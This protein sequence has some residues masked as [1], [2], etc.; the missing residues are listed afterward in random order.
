[1][2]KILIVVGLHVFCMTTSVLSD[3]SENAKNVVSSNMIVDH[4]YTVPEG[5]DGQKTSVNYGEIKHFRYYSKTAESDRNATIILPPNYTKSK[6]YPVLYLLHGL[7]A[8]EYQWLGGKPNEIIFNLVDEGKAKEMIVVMPNICM[9]HQSVTQTPEFYSVEHFREYDL[10]LDD[11][12]D[13]L[14]PFIEKNYAVLPGRDNRAVAGLSMGG[15]S[16]LHVGLTLADDFAYIGAFTPAVGVLP[17]DVESGLFR[18]E[19]LTLPEKYKKNT[20]QSRSKPH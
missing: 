19:T 16:A 7:G 12:R 18:K 20:L 9:R 1:M 4:N 17:Y 2:K 5:F 15:R 8:N 14:M 10:F 6:S 11:L 13:S 3:A